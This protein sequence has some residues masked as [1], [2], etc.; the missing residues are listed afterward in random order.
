MEYDV[1]I[2]GQLKELK[3]CQVFF[4]LFRG[5]NHKERLST[6]TLKSQNIRILFIFVSY[7]IFLSTNFLFRTFAVLQLMTLCAELSLM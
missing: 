5:L 3:Q 7:F 1:T 4:F 6:V 2:K